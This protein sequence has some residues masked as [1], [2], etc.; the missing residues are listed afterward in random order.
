MRSNKPD[1]HDV[2]FSSLVVDCH[3]DTAQRFADEGWDFT[4]PLAWAGTSGHLNLE[5]A[6]AG[7][8]GAEFFAAWVD[9][10]QYAPERH[11]SRAHELIAA[12]REQVSRQAS[13]LALCTSAAEIRS[14]HAEGRFAVLLALEGGHSIGS[15]LS[16][17]RDFHALGVRYLTLTWAN[18][19]AWAESSGEPRE[20]G[21]LTAFGRE[22]VRE[23]N[24]LG[25]MVDV[26]HASDRTLADVLATSRAPVLASHS[27]ARAL[28]DSP[29][30]LT[31]EQLRAIAGNGG[32]VMV[33]VYSAF[34]G[35]AYRH[36]WNGLK[37]EREEAHRRLREE[38]GP[39]RPIPFFVANRIERT[40]AARLPR[41]PFEALMAHFD[42]IVRVAG[43]DHV[44][45]GTDFDGISS[46]PEGMDSAA[47]LPKITRALLERGYTE[48]DVR[49]LLGENL[50]RVFDAVERASG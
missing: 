27:S 13:D 18:S 12:I 30:N 39:G 28:C 1:P 43:I 15:T 6:R 5:S 21:G 3:A 36:A 46:M 49:K 45:L 24:R 41:P 40:F 37:G 35:E 32:A 2:H 26:S 33:N 19:N 42:H 4:G 22:V 17:L 38:Y 20:S 29:R 16:A 8:L 48:D 44:G 47:D 14:A 9:P 23:M 25:M 31:D 50:M 7:G 34:V 10:A 11:V